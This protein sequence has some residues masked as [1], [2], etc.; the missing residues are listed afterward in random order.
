MDQRQSTRRR[1]HDQRA[2]R[3]RTEELPVSRR[4][5][6]PLAPPRVEAEERDV[7]RI[8]KGAE[9]DCPRL[10]G[11]KT[12]CEDPRVAVTFRKGA[13]WTA[14]A[15]VEPQPKWQRIPP[16]VA[17]AKVDLGHAAES[18]NRLLGQELALGAGEDKRTVLI[19]QGALSDNSR[20]TEH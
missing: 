5:T 16:F 19:E 13:V 18:I 3:C 2:M 12:H 20:Q 7:A 4:R 1:Q 17:A 11:S 8:R 10:A 15:L 6:Q 9:P 14:G